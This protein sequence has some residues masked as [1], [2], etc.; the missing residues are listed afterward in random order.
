MKGD[1]FAEHL[2]G[3]SVHGDLHVSPIKCCPSED[4]HYA[5][6]L[7]MVGFYADL[8]MRSPWCIR[9]LIRALVREM[10][11]PCWL[12]AVE[13]PFNSIRRLTLDGQVPPSAVRNSRLNGTHLTQSFFLKFRLIADIHES[14]ESS[15]WQGHMRRSTP[16]KNTKAFSSSH[17]LL[18]TQTRFFFPIFLMKIHDSQERLD[19]LP[20]TTQL[21]L[22]LNPFRC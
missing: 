13:V 21:S 18:S 10:P 16:H 8:V 1:D 2:F 4:V 11:L 3:D 9:Y 22:L 6:S 5:T 17:E 14:G 19:H 15:N 7:G 12:V 20:N